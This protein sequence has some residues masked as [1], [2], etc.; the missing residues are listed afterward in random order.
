M[1]N[2]DP[3]MMIWA[4]ITFG[5]L[6]LILY[7]VAWKPILSNIDKRE[8]TIQES[9]DKAH[10]AQEEAELLLEKH[11]QLMQNAEREAQKLL[12]ENRELSEKSRQEIINEARIGAENILEKAKAE[13]EKEKESALTALR[14]EIADLTIEATK[15]IIGQALDESK[16][17]ELV[18]DFIQKMPKSTNN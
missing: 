11:E 13:I 5:V 10:K 12:K 16:H 17:R 1:L 6:L 14:G 3:G 8:K 18:K 15:K 9:L 7:K 2:L 4:W